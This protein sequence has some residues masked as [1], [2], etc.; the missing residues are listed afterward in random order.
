[1]YVWKINIH[2]LDLVILHT[3]VHSRKICQQ[4]PTGEEVLEAKFVSKLVLPT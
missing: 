4:I 2:A 1:M 3:I